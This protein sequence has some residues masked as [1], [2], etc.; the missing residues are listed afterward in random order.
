MYLKVSGAPAGQI[1]I[2]LQWRHPYHIRQD[3]APPRS[4]ATTTTTERGGTTTQPTDLRPSSGE[5]GDL[6]LV[7]M[8]DCIPVY[9]YIVNITLFKIK[10]ADCFNI[11]VVCSY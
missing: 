3:P 6:A 8:H 4:G 2:S 10:N 11:H 5:S 9:S 1:D 7:R